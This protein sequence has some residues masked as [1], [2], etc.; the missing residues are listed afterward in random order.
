[1]GEPETIK[2]RIEAI[3]TFRGFTIFG[4]IFVIMVAGYH[5]LPLTFPQFGSA[6]VSTFKHAG[7]DGDPE[8][9]AFWEGRNPSTIYRQAKVLDKAV[10]IKG[11][12]N[13]LYNVAV[14]NAKG[15]PDVIMHGEK[16][17]TSKPLYKK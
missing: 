11:K 12:I 15:E 6:P 10:P 3:D 5:N 9:W 8:E 16:V 13:N 17:W 1:M 2:K 7:D 4:M 14:L